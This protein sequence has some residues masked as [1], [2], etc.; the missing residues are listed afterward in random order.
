LKGLEKTTKISV[1][2]ADIRA[3]IL[4]PVSPKYEAGILTTNP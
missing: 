1:M 3:E 2:R 4:N